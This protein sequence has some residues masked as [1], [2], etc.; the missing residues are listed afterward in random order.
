[1]EPLFSIPKTAK[2]L[3]ELSHWTIRLWISQG[4]LDSVKLGSRRM[5]PESEIR[6]IIEEGT[7]KSKRLP[8]K[9]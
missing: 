2:L 8:A 6:R 9:L 7:E 1:M 5:V 4:K 3:G